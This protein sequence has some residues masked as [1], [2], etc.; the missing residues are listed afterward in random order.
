MWNPN[1]SATHLPQCCNSFKQQPGEIR[2]SRQNNMGRCKQKSLERRRSW[3]WTETCKLRGR[4]QQ[5]EQSKQ[6]PQDLAS[7]W[8]QE[9]RRRKPRRQRRQT[10]NER[11]NFKTIGTPQRVTYQFEH[12][13]VVVSSGTK[14]TILLWRHRWGFIPKIFCCFGGAAP[15]LTST[16][17]AKNWAISA[18]WPWNE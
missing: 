8:A 12:V 15:G 6:Q 18:I 17:L 13:V 1:I 14:Q 3:R 10:E 5:L 4:Q 2:K 7:V 11:V 16:I 9:Q